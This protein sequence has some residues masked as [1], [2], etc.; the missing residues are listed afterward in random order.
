[1]Y[2]VLTCRSKMADK[3]IIKEEEEKKKKKEESDE[4][5]EE[6]EDSDPDSPLKLRLLR[7]QLFCHLQCKQI[8]QG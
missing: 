6:D 2:D 5:E 8:P 3:K 7:E 1:M 4:D